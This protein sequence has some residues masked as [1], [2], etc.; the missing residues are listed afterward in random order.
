MS[1]NLRMPETTELKPRITVFGV[2]GAGGNAVNNMI[3]ANLQGVD[4]VAANTDAQSLHLSKAGKKI[5]M[6]TVLTQGL[7]AGSRP[8]IGCG[9]AEE[10]LAEIMD[11]LE[12]THMAFITAGMG[13]GTGT[14][15]APVIAQ[16]AREQGILT[17]GVVTKPFQFEGAKR[18]RIAE[19]GIAELQ[20]Y[21]DTLIIIPNQNLFRVA[22][23]KT[24]FADAFGMADEVLHSGV[25]G[26]TDLMVMPGL[27]NLD[28]ADVRTVMDEMGKA[29]MGTGEATGESRALE[30]AEAAISNPLLDE[31]SMKGAKGVL[32]NITG[33]MDLTLFE[34]D[35]AANRIR[36]EVDPEANIIVGSTFSEDLDGTMR[37]S[38]VATGIMAEEDVANPPQT[39]SNVAVLKRPS[40]PAWRGRSGAASAPAASPVSAVSQAAVAAPVQAEAAPEAKAE[41][42]VAPQADMRVEAPVEEDVRPQPSPAADLIRQASD[43]AESK[44]RARTEEAPEVRAEPQVSAPHTLD[45]PVEEVAYRSP[46]PKRKRG[47]LFDRMKS[48]SR[49]FQDDAPEERAAPAPRAQAPQEN[50][51][52]PKVKVDPQQQLTQSSLIEEQLEIPAFLRRPS[53]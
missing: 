17:V 51:D 39:Q 26:I 27:I 12:N 32:I 3:E 44:E 42:A 50:P 31:V 7:G 48:G 28:F 23:E 10:S 30:A 47:G 14:G 35:E 6:G 11:A 52:A 19:A 45:S 2:G 49:L 13:G 25:R 4:F 33:G 8:E 5:Q 1:I 34:V 15:A 40:A 9:A 22:N 53:N 46:R 36:S 18:A 21:V 43:F 38:V 16:A 24:T 37:V 29:M 20:K 41:G